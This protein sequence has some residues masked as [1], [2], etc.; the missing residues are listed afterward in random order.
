MAKVYAWWHTEKVKRKR[1]TRR[2]QIWQE[3]TSTELSLG[4]R[5]VPGNVRDL[6]IQ[7]NSICGARIG[8]VCTDVEFRGP[9]L[10]ID[11][12]RSH[13]GNILTLDVDVSR[14]RFCLLNQILLVCEWL[15]LRKML[16]LG[17][18]LD[19]CLLL[20]NLFSKYCLTEQKRLKCQTDTHIDAITALTTNNFLGTLQMCSTLCFNFAL[21]FTDV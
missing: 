8:H 4:Q 15:D 1:R 12:G 14:N 7:W 2:R 16:S 5:I 21:H 11:G 19:F 18:S 6:C 13:F 10:K 20:G 17:G 3:L 9:F